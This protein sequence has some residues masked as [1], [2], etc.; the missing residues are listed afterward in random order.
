MDAYY[1]QNLYNILRMFY[2]S[3]HGSKLNT[4]HYKTMQNP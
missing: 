1:E 2:C 4:K 3:E